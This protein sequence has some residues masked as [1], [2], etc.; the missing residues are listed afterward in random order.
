MKEF[1]DISL[2]SDSAYR[3][4]DLIDSNQYDNII[5]YEFHEYIKPESAF[6]SESGLEAFRERNAKFYDNFFSSGIV[7]DAPANIHIA[8]R[9]SSIWFF[10]EDCGSNYYL[11]FGP[12]GIIKLRESCSKNGVKIFIIE[13]KFKDW[14]IRLTEIPEINEVQSSQNLIVEE[15]S[16][17]NKFIDRKQFEKIIKHIQYL[18]ISM[19]ERPQEYRGIKEENIRDK[20]VVPLNVIFEGRVNGEAKNCKGKTD[21]KI[22]SSNGMNSHIFEL[23]VWDGIKKLEEAITQL[24]GYLSWHHNYAGIIMFCYKKEFTDILE[25]AI[26]YLKDRFNFIQT[27]NYG[28]NELRFN[29][30]CNTDSNK[31]IQV[32]LT[33]INLKTV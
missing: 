33:F 6:N 19:Q 1:Q 10:S 29:L 14:K 26:L 3:F 20:M 21:I 27:H 18:T 28:E 11:G 8:I 12:R 22:T 25:K 31:I 7:D 4:A 23:K 13:E 2:I 9:I 24:Q 15:E 16:N 30:P 17:S 32:H 5:V